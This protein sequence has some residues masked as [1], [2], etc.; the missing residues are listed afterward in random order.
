MSLGTFEPPD[1]SRTFAALYESV[2]ES[3]GL[4]IEPDDIVLFEDDELIHE[5]CASE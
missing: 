1:R 5:D 4:D 2:C 3:C